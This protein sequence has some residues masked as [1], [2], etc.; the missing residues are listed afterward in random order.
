MGTMVDS[1]GCF[2]A[3]LGGSMYRTFR[4][5]LFCW[6]LPYLVAGDTLEPMPSAVGEAREDVVSWRFTSVASK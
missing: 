5:S 6:I 2:T 3:T 4:M 1:G